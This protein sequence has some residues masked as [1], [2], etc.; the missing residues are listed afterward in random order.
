MA[1]TFRRK[2]S[3]K[4]WCRFEQDYTYTQPN[5]WCGIPLDHFNRKWFPRIPLE[6]KA[7]SIAYWKYHSD[8]GHAVFGWEDAY[9][10]PWKQSQREMRNHY[11]GE[12]VKWLKDHDYEIIFSKPKHIWDLC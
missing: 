11:K 12:I 1:R 6:G 10:R 8:C 3:N 2:R 9:E 7:F 5:E 4:P